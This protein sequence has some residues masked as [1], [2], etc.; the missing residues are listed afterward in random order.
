MCESTHVAW[1]AAPSD[2]DRLFPWG[3]G[4]WAEAAFALGLGGIG[5]AIALAL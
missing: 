1:C 3:N 4:G 5:A 2:L